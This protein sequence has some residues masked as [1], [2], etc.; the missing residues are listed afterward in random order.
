VRENTDFI[1][2]LNNILKKN[3][4][5]ETKNEKEDI[6]LEPVEKLTIFDRFLKMVSHVID[7][8]EKQPV[9][10]NNGNNQVEIRY[11][12][13]LPKY[14][15]I[16]LQ[17]RDQ[18]FRETFMIQILILFQSLRQPINIM[19]KKYFR[20]PD[21]KELSKLKSRINKLLTGADETE[22]SSHKH[23][24]HISKENIKNTQSKFLNINFQILL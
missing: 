13:F 10:E 1:D 7:V 6:D 22:H 12:K 8:F 18:H 3:S 2:Y 24:K 5:I 20:I 11:P 17:F 9:T 4:T 23:N 14:K 21:K 16:N 19:Q 15:L